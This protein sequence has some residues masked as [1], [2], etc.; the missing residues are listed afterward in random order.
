MA[1][2]G[3]GKGGYHD[4]IRKRG[5]EEGEEVCNN[6]EEMRKGGSGERE[7]EKER[8]RGKR[9]GGSGGREIWTVTRILKPTWK[10]SASVFDDGR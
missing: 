3:E 5:R 2:W 7:R 10:A 9:R 8:K 6:G 1:G 4:L